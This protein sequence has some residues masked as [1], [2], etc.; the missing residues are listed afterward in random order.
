MP[1]KGTGTLVRDWNACEKLL[2]PMRSAK[3]DLE[4]NI[5]T[6]VLKTT[7]QR[8]KTFFFPKLAHARSS[9]PS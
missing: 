5:S 3:C 2:Q 7:F 4:G 1:L 6:G 9:F 8:G